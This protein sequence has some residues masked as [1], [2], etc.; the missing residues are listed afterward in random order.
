MASDF[1]V[2]LTPTAE[3]VYKRAFKEAQECVKRG[4]ATNA[5]VKHF[6]IIQEALDTIIPH[7]PFQAKRALSG[8]LAKI[9]RVKKGR[10]RICYIGRSDQKRII[11]IYISDTPRKEGDINDPYAVL[12]KILR[13]GDCNTFFDEL[14]IPFP[15]KLVAAAS[16]GT[17][18]T[19]PVQ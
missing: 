17:F 10:I 15:K 16:A 1:T 19:P 3:R 6:R 14:G 12:S 5:K 18:P 9:Y 13:S 7:D 8:T 2:E 4:D 11:V